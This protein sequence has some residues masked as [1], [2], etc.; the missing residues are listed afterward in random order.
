MASGFSS[1][2]STSRRETAHQRCWFHKMGNVLTDL[3]K[4]LHSRPKAALQ[5]IWMAP[6]RT[7]ANHAFKRFHK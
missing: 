1:W 5:A 7:E 4:A 3:P 2:R 6:T